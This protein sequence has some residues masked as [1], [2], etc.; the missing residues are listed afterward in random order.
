MLRSEYHSAFSKPVGVGLRHAHYDD[1]LSET[2]GVDFVELH[3]ENFF[4]AGGP[5]KNLLQK[6]T[7]R[8][9][10]SLH[11][12]ALGLGS[13]VGVDQNYLKQL[14]RLVEDVRPFVVSDHASFAW[15]ES[16]GN[17][18]HA[19]DLL[20][21]PF[22]EV[23]AAILADN[24]DHVQQQLGRQ[25]LIENLVN[26]LSFDH[27]SMPEMTFLNSVVDRSGCGLLLDLNNLLVNARNGNA[28]DPLSTASGWLA[29]LSADAV[30]EFHLA[31]YS[32]VRPGELI[33]DD[34][35]QPVA[36]E[37]WQLYELALKRFGPQT[38]L[39]EWDNN[40]PDWR[41]LTQEA[42]KAKQIMNHYL[43]EN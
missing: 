26:Y 16:A 43:L 42:S 30:Q 32:H 21:M 1:A 40:L 36:D 11:G 33:I 34:H 17:R 39:I 20:P 6:M 35:S 4:A 18:A 2:I 12:T 23:S 29:E 3:S 14:Q 28:N 9:P 19:G 31:G 22:T 7:E 5:I 10:V 24:I 41:R 37:C 15:T 25:L 8:Y 13:A 38:T 27:N